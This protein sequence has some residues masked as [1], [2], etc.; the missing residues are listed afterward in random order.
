MINKVDEKI[1]AVC[2]TCQVTTTHVHDGEEVKIVPD[3]LSG[4]QVVDGR[5]GFES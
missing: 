5:S 4:I 1:I 2:D 3:G